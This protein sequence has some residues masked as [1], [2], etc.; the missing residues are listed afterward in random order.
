M[1]GKEET[2]TLSEVTLL[3]A[4]ADS[5]G[6]EQSEGPP[7]PKVSATLAK[8]LATLFPGLQEAKR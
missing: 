3:Y 4:R 8:I 5:T 6:G 1:Q 7:P 2:G